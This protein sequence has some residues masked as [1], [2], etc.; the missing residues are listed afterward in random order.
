[1]GLIDWLRRKPKSDPKPK[2]VA[3]APFTDDPDEEEL[4]GLVAGDYAADGP[5]SDLMGF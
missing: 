3:P 5:I 4:L 2:P 1:M